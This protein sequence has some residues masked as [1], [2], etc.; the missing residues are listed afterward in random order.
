MTVAT[1]L[2]NTTQLRPGLRLAVGLSGGADSVALTRALAGRAAELGIVLHAAHLHHGLRGAEADGD[3]DFAA[4]LAYGLGVRF[5]THQVDITA[6]ATA[7]GESIEEA[8][9]RMRYAWFREL[10]AEGVVDA[11]ATAHTLDDQAE[12]V[13]GKLLRGAWTEGMSGI[14]P[15]VEFP[16]GRILRPMLGTTREQVEAYLVQ[17]GQVWRE[18]S[19]NLD[20]AY[21]RNRLRREL[22]PEL[23]RWNPRIREHL[24]NLSEL[25]R[26]EEAWWQDEVG[27]LAPQL[28]LT[29]RP[30][31]GGG[32]ASGEAG[33]SLDIVRLGGQ[34]VAVQRRLLRYAAVQLGVS[35]EFAAVESLRRLAVEGRAGQRLA[36]P[37]PLM[38]ERTPRELRLMPGT[39]EKASGASRSQSTQSAVELPVPGE[40]EA[41]G[42]RF[43][44]EA[45]QTAGQLTDQAAAS[46]TIRVW[47]AGD[48]V[49]LRYSSGPRKVKEV[50]ERLKVSGADRLAWPVIEWQGKI[51][52]MQGVELE[53]VSEAR[54]SAEPASR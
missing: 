17:I 47:R 16:E 19:S 11:V 42:W 23:E 46:A 6:E 49:T 26:D 33:V 29:G 45:R 31:R 27:R 18:D 3:R 41:F 5:H 15:V 10:M 44:A 35:L 34:S 54:F 9:R 25:A 52:W 12:T 39:P 40:A 24:A 51:V 1:L 43:R 32:R 28:L 48:R 38:A 36:L 13:L 50:L 20:P 4:G 53:A 7:H 8:A 21:T 22:L 30:V 37:G 2:L 14:F